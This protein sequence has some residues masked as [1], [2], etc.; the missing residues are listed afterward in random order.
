MKL[1]PSPALS[2]VDKLDDRSIARLLQTA[3]KPAKRGVSHRKTK[4]S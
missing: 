4:R 3:R 2:A 1:K